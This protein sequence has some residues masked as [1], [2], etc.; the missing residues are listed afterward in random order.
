MS[1]VEPY[2]KAANKTRKP[3]LLWTTEE[4]EILVEAYEKHGRSAASKIFE[5]FPT[6]SQRAIRAKITRLIATGIIKKKVETNALRSRESRTKRFEPNALHPQDDVGKSMTLTMMPGIQSEELSIDEIGRT[7][8]VLKVSAEKEENHGADASSNLFQSSG[9]INHDIFANTSQDLER[10]D[11]MNSRG[12][13]VVANRD[14]GCVTTTK[15]KPASIPDDMNYKPVSAFGPFGTHFYEVVDRLVITTPL[16]GDSYHFTAVIT[17]DE[18]R[19]KDVVKMAWLSNSK[20]FR[21]DIMATFAPR[22]GKLIPR[23]I[24]R[25]VKDSFEIINIQKQ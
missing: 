15:E 5:K 21:I 1:S 3:N 11:H 12:F 7:M 9:T 18:E 17:W 24:E 14:W 2:Q 25:V 23:S 13:R 22:Y 20:S 19:T 16:L 4:T 10:I 6:R 8:H